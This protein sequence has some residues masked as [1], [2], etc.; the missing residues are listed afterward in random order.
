MRLNNS[1]LFLSLIMA[2]VTCLWQRDFGLWCPV[3]TPSH[4]RS[5]PF[6]KIKCSTTPRRH[7]PVPKYTYSS[8]YITS[9]SPHFPLYWVCLVQYGELN[10]FASQ[11]TKGLLSFHPIYSVL[12][13]LTTDVRNYPE[14]VLFTLLLSV[15]PS[16]A[17]HCRAAEN[18]LCLYITI[19]LSIHLL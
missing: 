14:L 12:S 4:H 16:S 10:R 2:Q 5:W 13:P 1:S 19:S 6:A 11:D 3:T 17:I 8:S 15:M 7:T 9:V 18:Y